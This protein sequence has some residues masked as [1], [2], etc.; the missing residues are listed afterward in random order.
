MA[1]I[2]LTTLNIATVTKSKLRKLTRAQLDEFAG[3]HEIEVSDLE[4]KASVIDELLQ[5][6]PVAEYEVVSDVPAVIDEPAP[7]E[8]ALDE[9]EI[10]QTPFSSLPRDAKMALYAL[11][12][13]AD[14][15][16]DTEYE[17]AFLESAVCQELP[18]FSPEMAHKAVTTLYLGCHVIDAFTA[19]KF[20]VPLP[21][22]A[23]IDT[24]TTVVR[25][26]VSALRD[27][28]PAY[29]A[30]KKRRAGTWRAAK[31]V[32]TATFSRVSAIIGAATERSMEEAEESRFGAGWLHV[33]ASQ[34][35][36][37]GG[38]KSW[39]KY[40]GDWGA[41]MA[42]GRAARELG[43]DVRTSSDGNGSFYVCFR[44]SAA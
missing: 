30:P 38:S 26:M 5:H 35:V 3:M 22:L 8:T 14:M 7:A 18:W 21:A 2:D 32:S 44:A 13:H 9:D 17:G 19:D 29:V 41:G 24:L 6:K 42:P 36:S 31:S 34:I 11:T 33:H 16:C 15:A 37:L 20:V 1:K 43:N 40:S 27:L 10:D 23:T 25:P 39:A 4:T 12:S 28:M